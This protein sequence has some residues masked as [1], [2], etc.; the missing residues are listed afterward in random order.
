MQEAETERATEPTTDTQKGLH[1]K[2]QLQRTDGKTI[3]QK[4]KY[5]TLRYDEDSHDGRNARLALRVYA[6]TQKIDNPKL[7]EELFV[8]LDAIE[9]T[10]LALK[11]EAKKDNE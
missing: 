5:F 3:D 4:A 2:F 7:G 9:K 10:Y 8:E 11:K 1:Q 6:V